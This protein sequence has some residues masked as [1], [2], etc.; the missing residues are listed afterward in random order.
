MNTTVEARD[1]KHF[2]TVRKGD[3]ILYRTPG[4]Y[5]EGMALADAKCWLAFHGEDT[6]MDKVTVDMGETYSA[7]RHKGADFE[8]HQPSAQRVAD[9]VADARKFNLCVEIKTGAR[10]QSYIQISDGKGSSYAQYHI[11]AEFADYVNRKGWLTSVALTPNDVETK[12]RPEF[13]GTPAYFGKVEWFDVLDRETGK[14]LPWT[15]SRVDGGEVVVN[16]PSQG[17]AAGLT[18]LGAAAEFI[19]ERRTVKTRR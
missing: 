11:G 5:T 3:S 19:H 14:L 7:M 8:W 9:H 17:V 13:Y 2:G 16:H 4:Y 1:G 15:V 6:N 10:G 12:T 18:S